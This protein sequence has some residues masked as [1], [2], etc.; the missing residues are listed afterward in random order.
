MLTTPGRMVLLGAACLG[1]FGF[2]AL[3]GTAV[4]RM[5][6]DGERNAVLKPYREALARWNGE[7][8]RREIRT[9]G[10][11]AFHT[12][13]WQETLG[14]IDETLQAGDTRAAVAAW[15]RA[16][17]MARQSGEWERLAEIGDKALQIGEVPA[18]GETAKGA[19]RRSYLT[20][21]FRARARG[22]L[23]G[24][25]R[26][27]EGFATLGDRAVVEQA[28]LVASRLGVDAQSRERLLAM[29]ERFPAPA[30]AAPAP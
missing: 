14:R 30:A 27:A 6:F 2:G 3:F 7:R 20:A 10:R 18:F 5:R 24:V 12:A 13:E 22:S 23:D 11:H 9:T 17:A 26:A 8:M 15:R 28:L 29:S 19:A 21:L 1:L 4:D 16:Y 25:L